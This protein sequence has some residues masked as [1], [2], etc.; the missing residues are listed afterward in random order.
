MPFGYKSRPRASQAPA[1]ES[2]SVRIRRALAEIDRDLNVERDVWILD[3]RAGDDCLKARLSKERLD[4]LLDE[5]AQAVRPEWETGACQGGGPAP[6]G[7]P[8]DWA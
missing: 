1:P 8:R 4:V 6:H 5:R 3:R 7:L 2:R